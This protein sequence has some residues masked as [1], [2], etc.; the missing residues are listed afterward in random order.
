MG[1]AKDGNAASVTPL[2]AAVRLPP[3]MVVNS[4]GDAAARAGAATYGS[5]MGYATACGW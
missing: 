4:P 3:A 1:D 2:S 5:T